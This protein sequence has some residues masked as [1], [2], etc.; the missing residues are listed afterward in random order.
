M[1]KNPRQVPSVEELREFKKQH[2]LTIE[3]L[4]EMCFLVESAVSRWFSGN[5]KNRNKISY[6]SWWILNMRVRGVD[7]SNES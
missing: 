2:N 4:A 7:I 1:P 3:K 6:Q 5:D